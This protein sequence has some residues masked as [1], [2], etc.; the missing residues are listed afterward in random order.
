[1]SEGKPVRKQFD[2][3]PSERILHETPTPEAPLTEAF[4]QVLQNE[5][6]LGWTHVATF[7]VQDRLVSLGGCVD[8][9]LPD[10]TEAKGREAEG[11]AEWIP[12]DVLDPL[13]NR[14]VVCSF[15]ASNH[16]EV[17]VID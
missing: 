7:R 10:P 11:L 9:Q 14:W 4:R 1:M 5:I 6:Q 17:F 8:Q 2:H 16:R 13:D 12:F 15:V 3:L